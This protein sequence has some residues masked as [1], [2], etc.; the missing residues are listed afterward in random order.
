MSFQKLVL[1]ALAAILWILVHK[2]QHSAL[3]GQGHDA[4]KQ[5]ITELKNWQGE[6]NG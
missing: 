3:Q 4:R 6:N 5:L 2:D 1:R